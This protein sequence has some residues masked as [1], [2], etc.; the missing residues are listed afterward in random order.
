MNQAL[1]CPSAKV[2]HETQEDALRAARD[3]SFRDA[4]TLHTYKCMLCNFGWHLTSTLRSPPKKK[5]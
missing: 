2:R 1:K 5:K 3:A 4:P